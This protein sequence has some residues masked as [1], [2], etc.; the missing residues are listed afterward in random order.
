MPGPERDVVIGADGFLGRNL[1]PRLR[2]EGREGYRRRGGLRPRQV[3]QQGLL[4]VLAE[5]GD[6]VPLGM[7]PSQPAPTQRDVL[8][9]AEYNWRHR[10]KLL[11][12][13][14]FHA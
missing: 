13:G 10:G 8:A 12:A 14:L 9:P 4:G 2:A 7:Q 5:I 11:H 3:D 1:V 6:R